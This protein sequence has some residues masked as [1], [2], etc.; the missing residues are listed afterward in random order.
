M[1]NIFN[2]NIE[3]ETLDN[4]NFRKVLN[5]TKNQQLVVMSLKPN[6][7]IPFEVH[8]QNDQFF[9]V[10]KGKI[11][12]RINKIK[13][14]EL[15]DGDI[16]MIPAGTW[17]EI[18]NVSSTNDAKL[19]TIYSPPTHAPNKID[20]VQPK[21]ENSIEGGNLEYYKKKYLKYKTKYLLNK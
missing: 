10:E 19:Y 4:I 11:I 1:S 18:I 12:A 14:V 20:Y 6:E 5:T 13:D 2:I 21:N 3:K 7:H 8:L 15:N 17:H 16:I 9:R